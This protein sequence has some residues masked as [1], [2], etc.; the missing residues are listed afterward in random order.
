MSP[1]AV[2]LS[3]KS[4][5]SVA[6]IAAGDDIVL[7]IGEDLGASNTKEDARIK[8]K[9]QRIKIEHVSGTAATFTP[10]M[11]SEAGAALTDIAQEY[12]GVV[13]A[14]A[15]IFDATNIQAYCYTDLRGRLYLRPTPNAGADNTFKYQVYYEVCF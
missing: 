14:V 4:G 13:T 2:R 12:L 7:Q 15:A 11:F 3:R 1:T 10:S 5:T 6:T 8:V 9:I